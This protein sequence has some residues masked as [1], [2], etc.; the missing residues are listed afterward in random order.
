M[1]GRIHIYEEFFT[2]KQAREWM[3][4]QLMIYS[5]LAYDTTLNLSKIDAMYV[6]QGY[7]YASA[8]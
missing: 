6:V 4:R 3:E 7:R 5:P 8:D 2:Y 1:F